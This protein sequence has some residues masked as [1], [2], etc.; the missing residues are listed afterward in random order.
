MSKP[1][2][3]PSDHPS[4]FPTDSN[5][6]LGIDNITTTIII[7]GFILFWCYVFY[8]MKKNKPKQRR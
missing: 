1:R 6:H 2:Y 5:N 3:Q 8:R 4:M 7:V